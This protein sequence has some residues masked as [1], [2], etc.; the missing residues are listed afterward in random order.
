MPKEPGLRIVFC[1]PTQLRVLV[2]TS[3]VPVLRTRQCDGATFDGVL[4][5]RVADGYY[6]VFAAELV[7]WHSAKQQN[8][9]APAF[10]SEAS[11]A[12]ALLRCCIQF[13]PLDF[14]AQTLD[15]EKSPRQFAQR[16]LNAGL[17]RGETNAAFYLFKGATLDYAAHQ[18]LAPE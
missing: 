13:R 12:R 14:G 15:Q 7:S 3:I 5:G 1:K 2:T 18:L 16:E 8:R 17:G 4:T 6:C 11:K 9:P 10:W